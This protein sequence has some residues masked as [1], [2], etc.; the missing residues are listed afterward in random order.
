MSNWQYFFPNIVCR[1]ITAGLDAR[2]NCIKLN[3]PTN[4]DSYGHSKT[5]I[6]KLLKRRIPW[7]W[8]FC[9]IIIFCGVVLCN[10]FNNGPTKKDP[11]P[12]DVS[13]RDLSDG[14]LGSFVT[15][16]VCW[17]ID[18]YAYVW[19]A[20]LSTS[21]PISYIILEELYRRRASC[22]SWIGRQEQ[23]RKNQFTNKLR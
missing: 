23:P 9:C 17:Q 20:Q 3:L 1:W 10:I 6:G 15:I 19:R 4:R 14:C 12:G 5:T 18:V 16:S 13:H 21:A 11:Q 22:Y 8:V 2:N 7:L